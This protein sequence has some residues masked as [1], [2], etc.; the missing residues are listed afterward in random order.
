MMKTL[1]LSM[2]S[3]GICGMCSAS[4]LYVTGTGT[5]SPTDTA[6]TFV[7]PGDTFSV[8]FIVP[9]SPSINGSNSTTVS[10]D[11]PVF[12][13]TYT[14]NQTPV[15]VPE[16]TEVTFY[17]TADNGGFAVDFG[18]STE[19][20]F[21]GSQIFPGTTAAPTFSP[22]MFSGQTFL[23]LDSNNVDSNSSTVTVAP[24]PEPAS[25]LLVLCGGIGLIAVGAR[26]SARVC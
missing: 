26:K 23:F 3:L 18:P 10:F 25:I 16:P 8:Q 4:S 7:T 20:L 2:L 19:F 9:S 13:F 17:T 6:D 5:F 11:V 14:L 1:L 22:G 15:S 21:S 24:T 12:G